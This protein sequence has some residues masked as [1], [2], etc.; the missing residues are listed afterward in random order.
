MTEDVLRTASIDRSHRI[1]PVGPAELRRMAR[2]VNRLADRLVR[3]MRDADK[4]RARLGL[5]LESMADG[6][7]LVDEDGLVEFANPAAIRLLGDEAP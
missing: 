4:E 5:I 7:M 1:N 6:V 3:A 2:A